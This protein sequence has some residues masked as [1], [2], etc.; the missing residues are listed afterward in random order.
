M[1]RRFRLSRR[2]RLLLGILAAVPLLLVSAAGAGATP[3][4]GNMS[5]GASLWPRFSAPS[6]VFSADVRGMSATDELTAISLEGTFNAEQHPDRLYLVQEADDVFWQ[7][8]IP[9]GVQVVSIPPAP[10]PG[11]QLQLLLQRFKPFIKGAIETD[12]SNADTVNLASTMAGL[13]QAIVISPS[14]EPLVQSLGIPILYTFDTPA[15]TSD[16]PAQTYQW[17]VT[18]LLPKSDTELLVMLPGTDVNHIRDYAIAT[19]AFMFYLT[20][21]NSAQKPVF[22]TIFRDTPANTPVMG[23]I[24]NEGPDVAELSSL[25]HF[26]NASDFL[27][28]ESVWAAMPAPASLTEPSQP[29]AIQAQPNTVYVAFPVSDGDN[30]QYMQHHMQ[31]LWNADANLGGVP[32]GWTVAPGAVDFDPTL[33]E[34]FNSRLPKN[35]EFLA[36]PS[37]VG[38]ATQM[39]GSNLTTFARLT[40]Q[41]MRRDDIKTVDD[42]EALSDLTPYVQASGLSSISLGSR[43]AP[44]QVSGATV[45]GQTSGYISSPDQMFC[46]VL[47]QSDSMQ[48]GQPIFLQPLVDGWDIT[49]TS[50]LQIAQSLALAA[51]ASGEHVVFMTPTELAMTMRDY[52]AGQESGLPT[53]NAQSE[54]GAQALARPSAGTPF[55]YGSVTVT[56]SNLVTNPSGAE[57]TTGWTTADPT[58]TGRSVDATLSAATYQGQPALHWIDTITTEQDWVHYYPAV[59]NGDTYTFSVQVAGSGQIFMDPWSGTTDLATIPINLT[60]SYQTLTWTETIPSN[61][62]TGQS[63]QAPQLQVRESGAGP[64]DVYFRDASV[65]QSTARC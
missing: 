60:S 38:Y 33:L 43:L 2:L 8:Q 50:L 57:G 5:T 9:K 22:D 1:A 20:S 26:L 44:E 29:A 6:V 18:N 15:F 52:Y 35:S 55:P 51:Q 32:E 47:Q 7:A 4:G 24:P 12:P 59:Q 42:W 14:Q 3:M 10:S 17:G 64:V 41:Y 23:Y 61:A 25:G 31:Q 19:G 27:T 28:N 54:T 62:P 13:D 11:S 45:M 48:P 63:G 34:W 37:G 36:G 21:T 49:P 30:A 46:T 65:A 16:T 40:A 56:G 39:S 53:A 58:G